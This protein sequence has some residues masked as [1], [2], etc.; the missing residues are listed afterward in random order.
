MRFCATPGCAMR[1]PKGHCPAHA[2]MRE[3]GRYN[4]D[5]RHLYFSARWLRLRAQ[6][7][8][9]QPLCPT[10]QAERRIE[11][12]TDI[13]HIVPHRGDLNLFWDRANLQ[14]LCHACHS[15]KTARGE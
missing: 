1:V 4:A 13:D 6:V 5:M 11:P 9:E 14:A 8:D 15:A 3:Q 2:R 7:L 10:C 12:G